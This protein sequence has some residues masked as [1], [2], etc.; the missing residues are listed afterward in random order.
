MSHENTD[1]SA[2]LRQRGYRVTPQRLVVLDAVC[3]VGKHA[4]FG[5][6]FLHAR[7]LEPTINQATV[8]RALDVLCDAGLVVSA[9]IENQGKVYEISGGRSHHHLVCRQCGQQYTLTESHLQ[10]LA[11]EIF[12]EFAFKIESDHLIIS[13]LCEVCQSA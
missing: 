4:T 2:I 12:S 1:Y 6:I 8:Y 10:T 11:T 3:D 7:E 9:E 5:E 13:G